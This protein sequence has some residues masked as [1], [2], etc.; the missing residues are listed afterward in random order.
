MKN[1]SPFFL[2]IHSLH[3][4]L[5]QGY[6]LDTVVVLDEVHLRQ[7][8]SCYHFLSSGGFPAY[9]SKCTFSCCVSFDRKLLSISVVDRR[10]LISILCPLEE[11]GNVHFRLQILLRIHINVDVDVQKEGV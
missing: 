8:L 1:N 6:E 10:E 2:S 5:L 4:P 11:F 9:S 3:L 7:P